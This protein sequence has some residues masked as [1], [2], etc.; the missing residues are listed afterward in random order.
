MKAREI[1]DGFISEFDPDFI[2]PVS[3]NT[4]SLYSDN[5]NRLISPDNLI[6]EMLETG[7]PNIGVGII[8]LIHHLLDKDFK[9]RR[10]D[11][12]SVVIPKT[13]ESHEL[14]LSSVFGA[15]PSEVADWITKNLSSSLPIIEPSCELFGFEKILGTENIFPRRIGLQNIEYYPGN[16]CLFFMDATSN[17]DVIDY[18]NLR[19]A[20]NH[21]VPIP[22]QAATSSHLKKIASDFIDFNNSPEPNSFPRTTLQ[23]GRSFDDDTGAISF[24]N[25][26]LTNN[27][28][29]TPAPAKISIRHWYPRIWQRRMR[30][31]SEESVSTFY[32]NDNETPL[33]GN[34]DN[35]DL[36]PVSP[37]FPNWGHWGAYPGFANDVSYRLYG[38]SIPM[39]EV[40][41]DGSPALAQ[42]F[43]Y[44]AREA[45]LSKGGLTY[46]LS[47]HEKRITLRIPQ[48]DKFMLAWLRDCGWKVDLS[49]PGLIATQMLRSL[50]GPDGLHTISSISLLNLLDRHSSEKRT[51][52][53]P[54]SPRAPRWIKEKTLHAQAKKIISSEGLRFEPIRFVSRLIEGNV[55]GLG[56]ELRCPTCLRW[57]WKAVDNLSAKVECEQCLSIFSLASARPNERE[58]SYRPIGPF[59]V[60]GFGGGA[61][62]V[63]LTWKFFSSIGMRRTTPLLSFTAEKGEI[64]CEVDLALLY[65]DGIWI[66]PKSELIFAECKA[67]DRIRSKD[68]SRLEEIGAEFPNSILVISKF[69]ETLEKSEIRLLSAMV[70]RQR[71]ARLRGKASCRLIVL[72]ATELF[73]KWG[74]P[75]CWKGKG[76]RFEGRNHFHSLS[77]LAETTQEIHLGVQPFYDW[78]REK[79]KTQ[80]RSVSG[81]S[82]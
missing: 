70:A 63:L 67:Y 31:H 81:G 37:E 27:E 69:S 50:G 29:E 22:A 68:V 74:A 7:T 79:S 32:A 80:R 62:P 28:K 25:S 61:Y 12:L 20:G 49:S 60:R 46:C 75:E 23:V 42:Q 53:S 15:W 59:N 30:D 73:A 82:A 33:S 43:G 38:C 3:A 2:V 47:S 26:I 35:V 19:A 39:A 65:G 4:E 77:E 10:K 64:N 17:L 52:D 55:I 6:G 58:W 8:E 34:I 54:E 57:M 71:R 24:I 18:W 14:F 36:K 78:I 51:H 16:P 40:L 48:A 11:D 9:F 56:L 66:T 21:V 13:S 72:T 1:S 76:G 41:P 5:R 44:S 45:R